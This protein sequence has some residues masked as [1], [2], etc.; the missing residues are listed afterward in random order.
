[1]RLKT[2]VL[3]VCSHNTARSQ[4][5]AALLEK[6]GGE[7]FQAHSAGVEAGI[8]NPYAV[9][10]LKDEDIDISNNT[11]NKIMDFFKEGRHYHYVITVCDESKNEKCPIFPGLDA[12]LHWSFPDPNFFVGDEA[13]IVAQMKDLK[14]KIKKIV[15]EF[16]S[17]TKD[18]H[19]KSGFPKKWHANN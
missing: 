9:E 11:T 16:I 7:D 14:D 3:F 5:A 17:L 15:L 10:V 19:I 1:M 13:E 8:L 4:L 18:E 2:K 6:F 12:I